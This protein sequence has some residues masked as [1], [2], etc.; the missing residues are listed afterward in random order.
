MKMKR[1]AFILLAAIL[2]LVTACT[3]APAPSASAAP[4]GS[5]SPQ[6]ELLDAIKQR[7]K[8]I[9][10]TE[11]MYGPYEFHALI[12]GVDTIVG[13]DIDIAKELAAD[14]G[15]EL[16]IRDMEFDAL[17]PAVQLGTVDIAIAGINPSDERR[18]TV[19]F[20][21]I[22]YEAAHVVLVRKGEEVGY[23]DIASFAGKTV[24]AQQ[25]TT[26]ADTL[27]GQFTASTPRQLGEVPNLIVE[28]RNGQIDGL[29]VEVPVGELY[30]KQFADLAFS[31][32]TIEVEEGG[33]AVAV[34]KG[35]PLLVEAINKTIDRLQT[36]GL[37]DEYFATATEL[38]D[39]Q[40]K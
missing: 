31:P 29:I 11:A 2:L 12:D 13:M 18:E 37:I 36:A 33:T 32:F 19:D 40:P 21:K 34:P 14:I 30:L 17:I 20:S 35:S 8:L 16:E 22:Y 38:Y 7:G 27:T 15:V 23:T 10:G 28:L 26:M 3:S 1:I 39:Q 4:T 24:G 6:G 9:L 5:A 25:G